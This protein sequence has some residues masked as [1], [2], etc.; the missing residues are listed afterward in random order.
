MFAAGSDYPSA[1]DNQDRFAVGAA[2]NGGM[3][4]HVPLASE[5]LAEFSEEILRHAKPVSRGGADIVDRRDFAGQ[6]LLR[7]LED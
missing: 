6:R 3:I 4:W 5:A 2:G 7:S 1:P